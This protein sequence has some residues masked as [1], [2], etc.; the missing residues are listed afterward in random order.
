M[1][2]NNRQTRLIT[3]K[4]PS[5][6][7]RICLYIYSSD[8]PQLAI[9]DET[10]LSE[11]FNI[12]KDKLCKRFEW[13]MEKSLETFLYEQ[14]LSYIQTCIFSRQCTVDNLPELST[15][16]GFSS[17]PDFKKRFLKWLSISP[18]RLIEITEA[19]Y[20]E[21]KREITLLCM[22]LN[23]FEQD[24]LKKPGAAIRKVLPNYD[25]DTINSL[26]Y[27]NLVE[28]CPDSIH[29]TEDGIARAEE[30]EQRY[31]NGKMIA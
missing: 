21:W 15:K 12:P 10:L 5:L 22:Y 28:Q 2:H 26:D 3:A 17:F 1:T 8:I 29:L 25:A 18:E 13:K 6:A 11:I 31:F 4:R 30:L 9:L 14:R 16:L 20:S 7:E 19:K 24:M 23:S 27:E